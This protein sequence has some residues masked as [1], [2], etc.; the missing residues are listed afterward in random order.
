MYVHTRNHQ[1]LKFAWTKLF[2]T[3]F[4]SLCSFS[5][6]HK[7]KEMFELSPQVLYFLAKTK[8][9]S[10]CLPFL[11][12]Y[13][14]TLFQDEFEETNFYLQCDFIIFLYNF[15]SKITPLSE[16]IISSWSNMFKNV[17]F[18][19]WRAPASARYEKFFIFEAERWLALVNDSEQ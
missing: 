3:T 4:L 17:N 15:W 14:Y 7:G 19:W 9:L 1:R 12:I 13:L 2:W 18:L 10:V 5:I 11:K 8:L 6:C 16:W